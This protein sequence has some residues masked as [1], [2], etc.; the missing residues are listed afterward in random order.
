MLVAARA[1][2]GSVAAQRVLLALAAQVVEVTASH[3]PIHVMRGALTEL[4]GL[5]TEQAEEAL[6]V[7]L[8]RD[9]MVA[10]EP[11]ELC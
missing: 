4:T 1:P 7:T 3:A 8:V 11:A 9:P 2:C 6:L 10:T 5:S